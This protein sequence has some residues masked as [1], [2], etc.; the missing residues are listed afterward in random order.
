MLLS[1][2]EK[3]LALKQGAV[4]TWSMTL[5]EAMDKARDTWREDLS[6]IL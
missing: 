3:E 4:S 5:E 6:K 1:L 2:S